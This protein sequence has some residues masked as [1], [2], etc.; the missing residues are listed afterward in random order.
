MCIKGYAMSSDKFKK[1]RLIYEYITSFLLIAT[2]AAFIIGCVSIYLS[3]EKPFSRDAVAAVFDKID[4]LVYVAAAV[5]IIGFP[6]CFFIDPEKKKAK[7]RERP[8]SV[9]SSSPSEKD[10]YVTAFLIIV[11]AVLLSV[12]LISGGAADVLT[13]AVN[14]CTECIGLG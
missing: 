2:A 14:I 7:K 4:V 6:I 9:L 12:G 3:G 13:K 5:V 11:G 8:A 1:I 10:K